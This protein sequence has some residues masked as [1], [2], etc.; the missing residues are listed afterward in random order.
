MSTNIWPVVE[1]ALSP[2]SVPM[3]AGTY[4]AA[5]AQERP[6]LYLVY[7]LPSETPEQHADNGETLRG[8]RVQV[9]IYSRT[10]LGS[11]PDV[12]GAMTAAG[13]KRGPGRQ[14]P[15]N[16]DTRHHGMSRDYFYLA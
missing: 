11:L 13:F 1:A 12:D 2:L 8:Y 15:Y 10:G 14:L 4:V 3:A 6:D 7:S 9:N 5:T 16:P